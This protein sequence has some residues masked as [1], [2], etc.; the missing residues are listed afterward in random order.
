LGAA[1]S[2]ACAASTASAVSASQFDC[3]PLIAADVLQLC[4][5]YRHRLLQ[6][7]LLPAS[8]YMPA[9]WQLLMF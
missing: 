4:R 3:L 9:N 1:A 2:A 6:I 7:K 5:L 8:I